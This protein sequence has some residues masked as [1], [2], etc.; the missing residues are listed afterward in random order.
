LAESLESF[1]AEN[2][3]NKTKFG[4][5]ATAARAANASTPD[6][7]AV[8]HYHMIQLNKNY[9]LPERLAEYIPIKI[10]SVGG[11]GL[12]ALDRIIL[13][14][15]ERA[16]VVAINTDVQSLT[17]SVA[18][19]KVQL[20]RSVSRGLGAGGDPEVG[21][22]AALESADEIREAL[23][24]TDV[25]FVCAGLGGGTGSGA[26]PY[27][28]QAAR[29]AGALV[30]AF[31]TL[32]FAFEGKRRNAQAREALARL[33]EFAHAVV[34]FEN[35]R[36]GDLTAPQA[37]IHQAFAMADITISQSVR[38]IVNL[39]QRPGLIRIGFDDLLSALRT[40]NS[41]CLF[42]Y[43]ES[44]SDNRAH[45]ALTLA[46]KNPL[47]DRGRMLA[48]ATH[49]LVQVAGGPGMTLSE[50]EILMQE[51]GRHVSDQTHILFGAVVDGRLGNRLAVTII[52]SLSGDEEATLLQTPPA[53]SGASTTSSVHEQYEPATFQPEEQPEEPAVE[54]VSFDETVP[55]TE[56]TTAE[57]LP[58]AT[59]V[60]T[61]I[62]V[63]PTR[64]GESERSI[65]K[66]H[67]KSAS[68]KEE[69]AFAEK[70]ALPAKQEVLQ[71]EPVTRGRFEKSEPT[72]IEGE[73][74]DV[75][76]YLRKNI[77]VK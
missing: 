28:A 15:L 67:E 4:E 45:D 43:G 68:W 71:F 27:L 63:T 14:G 39:I 58:V 40:R 62:P 50:V 32:P 57:P 9:S 17:S 3:D 74:L 41:R 51:L 8:R 16:D 70:S 29:E 19:R 18:T 44:D 37:G 64:N 1:L 56:P 42:G 47:M 55:S 12:N 49:V 26:A 36:M 35:D 7:S 24:D 31:V 52:S 21:Y 59:P 72:I 76:T 61:E 46:L 66:P 20:G 75:P 10:A 33:S 73:D 30:I 60:S 34:C 65:N 77:K 13:D 11:A 25:I 6:G 54:P 69:K 48:D 53:A 5:D 2:D 22:Q 38:S 23:A